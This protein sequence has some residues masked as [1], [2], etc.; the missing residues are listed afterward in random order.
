M[1]GLILGVA[2]RNGRDKVT[3]VASPPI[4]DFGAWLE[5][6]I[7]ESTGKEGKG[8]IPLDREPLGPPEVY[9][10]DRL[11]AYLRTDAG[12]DPAQDK[13]IDAL[14]KA[15]HPVVRIAVSDIYNL[16]QE[17]F[18]WEIATAVAGSL[19]GINA[20]Q[21]ARCGGEQDRHENANHGIR[22]DRLAAGG[23]THP[24]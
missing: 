23:N 11:F 17:M 20:F 16:G 15:G 19:L 7:A 3:L 18:R 14:T 5:Q 9:G 13:A 8:I 24:D 2:A 6:L 12:F 4:G 21:P 1:L 22:K 10:K